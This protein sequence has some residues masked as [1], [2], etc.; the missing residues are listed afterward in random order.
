M[1]FGCFLPVFATITP[2]ARL[3][4]GVLSV[5][6]LW[7]VLAFSTADGL[8]PVLIAIALYTYSIKKPHCSAVAIMLA[9]LTRETS[10]IIWLTLMGVS[11]WESRQADWR[12]LVPAIIPSVLWNGYVLIRFD[13]STIP[14]KE[15]N[16]VAPFFGILEKIK[17]FFVL[18]FDAKTGLDGYLFFVLCGLIVISV[19]MGVLKLESNKLV[20]LGTL[21]YGAV[22][23]MS[24]MHILNYMFN[25]PRTFI[26]LYT[27]FF[28]LRGGQTLRICQG[29]M[30]GLLTVAS[31]TFI[32]VHLF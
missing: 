22:V 11:F 2:L 7:I 26:D 18:E 31:S 12:Y 28:F 8:N 17:S 9:C 4:R 27:L 29:V 14:G 32:G 23:M 21:G 30:V 13:S 20:F 1:V 24:S 3:E 15:T 19:V 5:P 25:Y 10:L 16:F 6:G